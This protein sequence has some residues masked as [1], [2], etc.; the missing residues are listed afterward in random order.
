M[1]AE[2][3]AYIYRGNETTVGYWM[4]RV[5]NFMNYF[6]IYSIMIALN[7][8]F[9][10]FIDI[11][12][13]LNK[14]VEKTVY[15]LSYVGMLLL[16]VS[17]FTH[18]Y[19]YFD[20]HNRY[21]RGPLFML[22]FV[23]PLFIIL[24]TMGA[25]IKYRMH[26]S[27]H[28]FIA[29]MIF[30]GLPLL[31]ALIQN[32]LYGLSL[33]NIAL[34]ISSICIFGFSLVDH[35]QFLRRM[36]SIERMTG[37]PNSYGF[38]MEIQKRIAKG[39][40]SKYDAMYLDIVRMGLINRKYGGPVGDYVIKKYAESVS[41]FM[42]PEEVLG[43]LGG[44]FFVALV[45]KERTKDFLELISGINITIH[46]PDGEEVIT[47]SSVAGVFG[48]TDEVRTPD[49][50]M[51]NISMAVSLAKNVLKKPVVFLTPE[52]MEE[53]NNRRRLQ[54]MIPVCLARKEFVA[55]YQPKVNLDT[56]K[57]CGAEAL[58]R[59]KHDGKLVPPVQFISVM[60]QNDYICKFDFYMLNAVCADIKEWLAN[61]LKP[62]M[63]SVNF[64]RRN[65]GNP[66]LAEEIYNVVRSYDIPL[67]LIQIEITETV[68]EYPLEY[69]KGVVEALHRYGISAAID[70]FGTGSSSIRTLKDVPFDLLKIDKSFI[71]SISPKDKHVLTYIIGMARALNA[72]TITEGVET[73]D[74]LQ[75]LK[76]LGCDEIQGYYFDK[77]L[78]KEEFIGRMKNPFYVKG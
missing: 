75:V 50:V 41:E 30:T 44:N 65:L 46:I 31:C 49:L 67:N 72:R 27:K 18:I 21:V 17:Q 70:D 26:V 47:V 15:L 2:M 3:F 1:L 45:L 9:Y 62:P 59:W 54:E 19:Y 53:M 10:A 64:S 23:M 11:K 35:N 56:Y 69:L 32:F 68:D 52:L 25:V 40:A 16:L 29:A 22:S 4:V 66:I 51:N 77:P 71:D 39:E 34:G 78:P 28:I 6:L 61:G 58:A 36:A 48:L 74:Q 55:F 14:K 43:R 20:E 63:I 13:S 8:F 37:L 76:E 38:I 57:L 24:V 7:K 5:C 73:A 60:E 12:D 33:F 42:G